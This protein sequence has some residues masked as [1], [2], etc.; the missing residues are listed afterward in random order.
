[1]N[2]PDSAEDND[3]VSGTFVYAGLDL[4][5]TNMFSGVRGRQIAGRF[6]PVRTAPFSYNTTAAKA[7]PMPATAGVHRRRRRPRHPT[8]GIGRGRFP[9]SQSLHA[10][11]RSPGT[12]PIKVYYGHASVI[13]RRHRRW[14]GIPTTP[15]QFDLSNTPEIITANRRRDRPFRSQEDQQWI[16][17]QFRA[18]EW[19]TTGWS[20]IVDPLSHRHL[21]ERWEQRSASIATAAGGKPPARLALLP[22]TGVLAEIFCDPKWRRQIATASHY[23]QRQFYLHVAHRLGLPSG[24]ATRVHVAGDPLR[25]WVDQHQAQHRDTYTA[26]LRRPNS[27]RAKLDELSTPQRQHRGRGLQPRIRHLT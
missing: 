26:A 23:G 4:E 25:N 20:G 8:A 21:A 15:G 11:H 3:T 5:E 1:M 19:V 13:C 16:D 27:A 2:G 10:L 7:A 9:N 18:A 12:P 14:L 17:T 22:E 24:F 6:I